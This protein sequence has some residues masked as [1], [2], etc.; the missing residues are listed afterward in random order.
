MISIQEALNAVEQRM[1]S[2]R[3]E[4][5]QLLES[6][7]RILAE[8]I[9]ASYDSPTYT[10]SAMDGFA[11][12]WEDVASVLSG[13]AVRLRVVGESQAGGPFTGVVASGEAIRISTGAKLAD[14][15]DS[16]IPIEDCVVEDGFVLVQTVK[17]AQQHVRFQGEEFKVGAA[18]LNAGKK[19]GPAQIA[20]LASMGVSQIRVYAKPR[21]ALIITGKELVAYDAQTQDHTLR[22]SNT[23]MLSTLV[24]QVGGDVVTALRIED[25]LDAT[26]GAIREAEKLAEIIFMSGGV[27]MGIHDHVKSA[28]EA[29]DYEQIFW[30]VNQKPGKPLFFAA[31]G[32]NLLLGLPGNPVSAFMCFQ[33]YGRPLLLGAGGG[34]FKIRTISARLT[35]KV[36]NRGTRDTMLRVQLNLAGQ[37][38]EATVLAQQGSHMLTSVGFAQGYFIIGGQQELP[39]GSEVD[40]YEF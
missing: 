38:L 4:V 6:S 7:G 31:K 29:C 12:R 22:D 23:P 33:H 15:V 21:V 35:D 30:K 17:K 3:S 34:S 27:S 24:D 11:V 9:L 13:E 36:I 39:A 20:L 2:P 28:A 26:I 40:I 14:S 18:L 8:D 16:V 19:I 37:G 1:L 32:T 10:N 25:D 5:I